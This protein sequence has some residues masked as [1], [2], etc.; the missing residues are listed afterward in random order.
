[1]SSCI[2]EGPSSWRIR[3]H[4]IQTQWYAPLLAGSTFEVVVYCSPAPGVHGP[5]PTGP[6]DA[7]LTR[8][9][10]G[11][12]SGS[13]LQ[14]PPLDSNV[15]GLHSAGEG[16]LRGGPPT[17]VPLKSVQAGGI[18]VQVGRGMYVRGHT[19]THTDTLAHGS[20]CTGTG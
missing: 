13:K 20:V 15:W 17:A 16:E 1:M 8:G 18:S 12:S 14:A 3:C 2:A 9:P 7:V 6:A 4:A 5:A 19:H 10:L 11:A